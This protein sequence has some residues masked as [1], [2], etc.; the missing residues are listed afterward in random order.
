MRKQSWCKGSVGK[1][2]TYHKHIL[3]LKEFPMKNPNDAFSYI[4]LMSIL[5][6]FINWFHSESK[7]KSLQGHKFTQITL[8]VHAHSV[9]QLSW[10]ISA[11][12]HFRALPL[13]LLPG[14][15]LGRAYSWQALLLPSE[16]S[17]NVTFS[18]RLPGLLF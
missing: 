8:P 2:C 3:L 6:T 1:I 16:L 17:I 15:L 5:D 12:S 13:F 9:S 14:V 18:T 10:S 4:N 11:H 7:L